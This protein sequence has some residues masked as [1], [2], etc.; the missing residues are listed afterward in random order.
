MVRLDR[1][2]IEEKPVIL[3]KNYNLNGLKVI[4]GFLYFR[5][6]KGATL[7]EIYPDV[8]QNILVP[9]PQGIQHHSAHDQRIFAVLRKIYA[10][11]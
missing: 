4:K 7:W 5:D 8:I 10:I 6:V 3:K 9:A 1:G 11:L 2:Y